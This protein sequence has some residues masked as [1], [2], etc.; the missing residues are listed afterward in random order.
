MKVNSWLENEQFIAKMDFKD[1]YYLQKICFKVAAFLKNVPVPVCATW[2]NL[3]GSM[4]FSIGENKHYLALDV[5]IS[6]YDFVTLIDKWTRQFYPQYK[7][8]VD[9]E[10]EYTDEEILD[11]AKKGIN[12]NDA[13]LMRKPYSYIESGVIEKIFIKRD[14]FIFNKNGEN[15]IRLSGTSV[16]NPLPLSKFMEGI[17]KISDDV[18]KKNYIEQNSRVVQILKDNDKE[19]IIDYS[20]RQ[21]LNFFAINYEDYKN[22]ILEQIDEFQYKWGKFRVIF[23]SKLLRDDCLA[24][25]TKKLSKEK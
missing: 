24:L 22:F 8:Q 19:I 1:K 18:E 17:R 25:Y 9:T 13:L 12:L 4:Y 14:E 5:H 11:L 16:S 15:Q 23:E 10:I 6:Y 3:H 20:G 21:M 2:D 7:V